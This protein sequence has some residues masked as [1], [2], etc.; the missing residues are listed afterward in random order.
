MN[1]YK[2]A[3]ALSAVLFAEAI[4]EGTADWFTQY[5]DAKVNERHAEAERAGSG[6]AFAH[7]F[8]EKCVKEAAAT[9]RQHSR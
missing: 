8:L 4:K 5:V 6:R 9:L 2:K 3:K 1:D 7:L